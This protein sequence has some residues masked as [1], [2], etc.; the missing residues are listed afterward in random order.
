[1]TNH[2]VAEITIAC[3]A[4]PAGVINH[5][6]DD[7]GHLS[8]GSENTS[9]LSVEQAISELI[10]C[11]C[12]VVI[13]QLAMQFAFCDCS[14]TPGDLR[15]NL[16]LMIMIVAYFRCLLGLAERQFPLSV[17]TPADAS[18]AARTPYVH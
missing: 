15:R 1:M 12:R 7:I 8:T 4:L 14:S 18:H 2:S 11:L 10:G 13:N 16:P 6:F 9:E 3:A 17:S 5:L